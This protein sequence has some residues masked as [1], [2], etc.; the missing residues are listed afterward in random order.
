MALKLVSSKNISEDLIKLLS[1]TE[2]GTNGAR[3]VH[4]DTEVRIKEA[5]NPWSFSLERN[6]RIIGNVTFCVR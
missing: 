5:D 4:L 2:L 3:Y 1:N 6:G